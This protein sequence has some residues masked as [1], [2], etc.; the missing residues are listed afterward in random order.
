MTRIGESKVV[1][2]YAVENHKG[3]AILP[4]PPNPV[5]GI[6]LCDDG[7]GPQNLISFALFPLPPRCRIEG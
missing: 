1:R 2:T 3:G 6:R 5:F 7:R 4:H